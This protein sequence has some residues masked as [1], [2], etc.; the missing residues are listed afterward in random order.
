MGVTISLLFSDV[1][2]QDNVHCSVTRRPNKGEC[3]VL[4][5]NERLYVMISLKENYYVL[6]ISKMYLKISSYVRTLKIISIYNSNILQI[7]FFFLEYLIN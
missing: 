4:L 3:T 2:L 6:T 1:L 5:D 7:Y